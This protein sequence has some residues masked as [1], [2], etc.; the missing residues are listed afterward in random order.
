[1]SYYGREICLIKKPFLL[2]IFLLLIISSPAAARDFTFIHLSDG[3]FGSGVGNK[4]S[5]SVIRS[6]S[7]LNINPAFVIDSGDMTEL[8]SEA[9]YKLYLNQMSLLNVPVY[10][11]PGNHESRWLDASKELF[12]RYL[13]SPYRSFTYEGIHFVLLDTSVAGENFGHLDP[14]ML[15]WLEKDLQSIPKGTPVLIFSHHPIA[16]EANRF[17][18]NDDALLRILEPYNVVAMFSGHGHLHLRWDRN[19][20]PIFMTKAMMESGFKVITIKD[21]QLEIWNYVDDKGSLAA[22]LPLDN[23]KR[24]T[25]KANTLA[26][27]A[28]SLTVQVNALGFTSNLE[29]VTYRVNLGAWQTL[30]KQ[31]NTQWSGIINTSDL[32]PGWHVLRVRG[33]TAEGKVFTDSLEF[34]KAGTDVDILWRY[35]TNGSIQSKPLI[36]DDIVVF[37]SNDGSIYA[38]NR[39]TGQLLWKYTTNNKVIAGLEFSNSIIAASTDGH[40]YSLDKAGRLNWK[41]NIGSP[42]LGDIL[43]AEDKIIATAANGSVYALRLDNGQQLWSF[44]T[45]ELLGSGATYGNGL[46]YVGSWDRNLYALDINTGRKIWQKELASRVY[47]APAASPPL[48]AYGK[49]YVSTHADSARNSY[50]LHCLDARTGEVLWQT[51]GSNGYSTPTLHNGMIAVSTSGGS[52]NLYDPFTGKQVSSTNTRYS[53]YGSSPVSFGSEILVGTLGGRYLAVNPQENRVSWQVMLTDNYLFTR[54]TVRDIIYVPSMDGHLYAIKAPKQEVSRNIP[55]KDTEKHWAKEA[56]TELYYL[57]LV[58]GYQDNTFRPNSSVSRAEWITLL[59]RYQAVKTQAV[60][61]SKFVDMQD[62]WSLTTVTLAEQRGW[63]GGYPD[64][65]GNYLFKPDQSLTRAEA[66]AIL[67]RM[68]HLKTISDETSFTDIQGHWAEEVIKAV[69]AANLMQGYNNTFKPD[70][71]ITRAEAATIL[72]R[73]LQR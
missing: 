35:K 13:N 24:P 66:A 60:S 41:T 22:R 53:I 27:T 1:M 12:S 69:E 49:I 23:T 32:S 59:T 2:V 17:I 39:Y 29:T 16:Y 21:D 73:I 11:V 36:V 46:V 67:H 30:E 52:V 48:Y 61:E 47:F 19:G 3:H 63:V 43:I 55:F 9:E 65:E 51:T 68:L 71:P 14:V 72:Y 58:T 34:Y 54:S 38:L 64:K 25:L 62:H 18:D 33:V 8:G 44:K 28:N 42:I 7:E 70:Q 20:I 57:G 26:N 50:T 5:P 6:I 56:I 37:G 31:T 45:G 40:I 15:N 10:G 4:T